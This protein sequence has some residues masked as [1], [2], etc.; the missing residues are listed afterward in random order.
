MTGVEIT[1]G[2]LMP[3]ILTGLVSLG[4]IIWVLTRK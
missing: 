2:D 4:I 3:W 1:L